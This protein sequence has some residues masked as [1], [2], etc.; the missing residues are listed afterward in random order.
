M[1][2]D[3]PDKY[4]KRWTEAFTD[5]GS[6]PPASSAEWAKLIVTYLHENITCGEQP[7]KD[8]IYNFESF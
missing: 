4:I 8:M 1:I 7:D 5:D 6:Y 2:I 3:I